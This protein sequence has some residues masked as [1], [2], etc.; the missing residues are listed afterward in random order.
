E[1]IFWDVL[2]GKPITNI[3]QQGMI[4]SIKFF[5]DGKTVVSL[6]QKGDTLWDVA[7]HRLLW[8]ITNRELPAVSPDGRSLAIAGPK[9]EIE[10]WDVALRRIAAT[11]PGEI[12]IWALTFSPDGK[13]LAVHHVNGQVKLWDLET[14]RGTAT[15]SGH[16]SG[17]WSVVFS[18]DGQTLA[19]ASLDYTMRLWRA[20]RGERDRLAAETNP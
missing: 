11:L 6:D 9:N 16:D 14:R 5:P 20:A 8:S 3:A 15:L 4:Y 10:L 18:H 2:T 19:T 12:S 7:S 17:G 1:L 13:R